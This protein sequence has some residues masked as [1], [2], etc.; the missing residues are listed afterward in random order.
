METKERLEA[1]LAQLEATTQE[2]DEAQLQAF[3][4]LTLEAPRIFFAGAGRSGLMMR[5]LAMRFMHLG[6]SAYVVGDVSTPA[7]R[8]GD[9][10]VMAS[11]S[12]STATLVTIATKAVQQLGCKLILITTQP[13]SPLGQ[14]A[15]LTITVH[16]SNKVTNAA[17]TTPQLQLGSSTFEEMT[18]LIG[19]ALVANLAMQ[20]ELR[21][22]N[23]QLMERHANLE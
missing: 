5:A 1:L 4:Q 20:P 9:L 22:T 23:A 11:G 7:A 2:L 6:K 19:D 13:D 17:S 15:H 16:A 21:C 12:G 8:P 3:Q 18:L 10:L 14:L